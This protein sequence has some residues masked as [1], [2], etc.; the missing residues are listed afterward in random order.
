MRSFVTATMIAERLCSPRRNAQ[1]LLPLLVDRLVTASV[2]KEQLLE[3]RFPHGDQVYVHGGDGVLAIDGEFSHPY[4]PEG[5]SL[6]EMGTE[7]FPRSKAN[8]DFAGAEEELAS[9]F[10]NITP[11]VTSA[12]ATYVCVTS[13]V[14]QDHEKWVREKKADSFWKAVRVVDA[15][16]LAKWL[17]QAP[18]VLL[19]FAKE[20]GLPAEGLYD[21]EQYIDELG[22]RFGA[23]ISPDLAIAGRDEAVEQICELVV[24]DKGAVCVAGESVEEA[25]AFIAATFLHG[26]DKLADVPPLV[27]A[28][29]RADLPLLAT[30]NTDIS[31]VP[32]DTEA[33]ARAKALKRPGW[34]IISPVVATPDSDKPGQTVALRSVKRGVVE[35]HLVETLDIP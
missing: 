17:E 4:I 7:V 5:L 22:I 20:C 2:P 31:F 19:W 10:P 30:Y 12:Q 21:A 15:V 24:R 8:K 23:P 11:P 6:W 1:D 29:H 16:T 28:D 26:R 27:L 13:A 14:F 18:A 3:S 25:A 9:A 35:K 32:L 33:A 34:R